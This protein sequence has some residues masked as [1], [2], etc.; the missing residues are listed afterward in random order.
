VVIISGRALSFVKTDKAS[1]D[2]LAL[3]CGISGRVVGFECGPEEKAE[4][5]NIIKKRFPEES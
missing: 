1:Y 2:N 5:V 4:L 3:L